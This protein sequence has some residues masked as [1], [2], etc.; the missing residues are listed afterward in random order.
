M[1]S[2]LPRQDT[3]RRH[4]ISTV[5][6]SFLSQARLL[7]KSNTRERERKRER[8]EGRMRCKSPSSSAWMTELIQSRTDC[9]RRP[10]PVVVKLGGRA[11]CYASSRLN[12]YDR[13]RF[14][15]V[16]THRLGIAGTSGG[17]K[18]RFLTLVTPS[19]SARPVSD[20]KIDLG[21][22]TSLRMAWYCRRRPDNEDAIESLLASSSSR[23]NEPLRS[24]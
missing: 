23:D 10:V 8:W 9:R 5:N 13:A 6:Q 15:D 11:F 21:N 2:A 3:T 18:T 14:D 24:P 19:A 12:A 17:K 20:T 16:G 4:S 22:G 7:R 1:E